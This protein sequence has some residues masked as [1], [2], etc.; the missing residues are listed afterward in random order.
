MSQGTKKPLAEATAV[1]E[2]IK[3]KLNPHCTRIEIAGSIRRQ[4]EMVG[5]IELV[6]VPKRMKD[7]LGDPVPKAKTA[8]DLFFDEVNFTPE[9]NG[10]RY[11]AFSYGGWKVD[12]YTPEADRWGLRLLVS[13]GSRAFNIW[14]VEAL[15][16]RNYRMVGGQLVDGLSRPVPTPEE[17]DVFTLLELPYIA[18]VDRHD[19]IW[20]GLVRQSQTLADSAGGL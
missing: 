6:A 7:L 16:G 13:T 5:D 20:Y 11:K 17:Q 15:R 10:D 18:P 9:K 3:E 1:A 2:E 8:L 4:R 14:A 19:G 12:L